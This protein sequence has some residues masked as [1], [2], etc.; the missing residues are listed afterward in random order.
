MDWRSGIKLHRWAEVV[1]AGEALF[2]V[3]ARS[4]RFNGNS[5]TNAVVRHCAAY[6]NDGSRGFVTQDERLINNVRTNFSVMVIVGVASANTYRGN[7]DQNLIR[8]EFW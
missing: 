1:S 4:L 2:T 5:L 3:L 6:G 7:A 8:L